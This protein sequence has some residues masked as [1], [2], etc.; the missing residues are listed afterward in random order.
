MRKPSKAQKAF[1]AESPPEEPLGY[2]GEV[3]QAIRII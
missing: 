2:K 1:A 3:T